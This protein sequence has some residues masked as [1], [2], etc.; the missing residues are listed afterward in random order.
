MKRSFK[1]LALIIMAAIFVTLIVLPVTLKSTTL[2]SGT[3]DVYQGIDTCV[4]PT[5]TSNCQCMILNYEEP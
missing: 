4:C 2:L 3:K 1:M 5:G